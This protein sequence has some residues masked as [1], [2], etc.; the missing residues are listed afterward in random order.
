MREDLAFIRSVLNAER[1]LR[2]KQQANARAQE[3]TTQE[4]L[5]R[6]PF[7]EPEVKEEKRYGEEL[8]R[9]RQMTYLQVLSQV[10]L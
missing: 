5:E 3:E 6:M 9:E 4:C 8:K 2:E 10:N 7:L 1:A